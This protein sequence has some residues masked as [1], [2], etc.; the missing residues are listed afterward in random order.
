V[1]SEVLLEFGARNVTEPS[2]FHL[3]EPYITQFIDNDQLILPKFTVP[4]LSPQR[5]F[6]EK[7]TLIHVECSR[8]KQHVSFALLNGQPFEL[9]SGE[10]FALLKS[11][12]ERLSRHWYDLTM[13]SRQTIGQSALKNIDLL[14][15]VIKHKKVFFDGKNY[16]YD[17]CLNGGF[18]LLPEDNNIQALE[19]DYKKM[20]DSGMFFKE[21]PSFKDILEELRVV[22]FEIN[23]NIKILAYD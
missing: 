5:T 15:E 12:A 14:K 18:L 11:N 9:L 23:K 13:L 1:K 22:E 19:Q 6:W 7:A 2:E 21:P 20:I 17:A 8:A 3:I 10:P 4:V 16:N